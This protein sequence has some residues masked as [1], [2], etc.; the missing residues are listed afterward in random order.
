MAFY[1][2]RIVVADN[3]FDEFIASLFSL[4]SEK[5]KGALISVCTGILRRRTFIV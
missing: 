3:K 1:Q 5:S 4:S 2:L